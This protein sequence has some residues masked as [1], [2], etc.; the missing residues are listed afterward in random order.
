MIY[1]P[2]QKRF[3]VNYD[4]FR[5]EG[6]WKIL[7]QAQ[8]T[9]GTWSDVVFGSV[10]SLGIKTDATIAVNLNQPAYQV[11]DQLLF[12]VTANG[13]VNIDLYV[14][15][16]FPGGFFQCVMY[17]LN[18]SMVNTLMPYQTGIELSGEKTFPILDFILPKGIPHGTY[19]CY[20]IVTPSGSDPWEIESWIHFDYKT[21]EMK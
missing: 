9:D 10:V 11:G 6:V 14:A 12:S 17:P 1:N 3:E 8:G 15:I 21:F 20:G 18:F 16:M 2:D 13:Q 4:N 5:E 7:Y 19:T